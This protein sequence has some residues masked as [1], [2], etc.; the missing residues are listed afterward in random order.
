MVHDLQEPV[1]IQGEDDRIHGGRAGGAVG[2]VIQEGRLAQ[3][4]ACMVGD[5]HPF[6][7]SGS[8]RDPNGSGLDD[9]EPLPGISLLEYGAPGP[10]PLLPDVR[11]QPPDLLDG[12]G[13]ENGVLPKRAQHVAH[14]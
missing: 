8:A 1:P 14:G 9:H 3:T 13:P 7:L 4:V 10:V 2:R 11:C 12:E 6:P 5:Q